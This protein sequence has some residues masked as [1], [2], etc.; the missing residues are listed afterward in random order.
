MNK[1][2][3]IALSGIPPHETERYRDILAV[4]FANGVMNL[5]GGSA[6]LHFDQDGILQE[7]EIKIKRRR[8]KPTIPLQEVY[9]STK[10]EI[11]D[12]SMV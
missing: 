6:E 5:R 1:E 3:F 4:M 2:G 12:R 7:I 8:N 9:K 10:V 11:I